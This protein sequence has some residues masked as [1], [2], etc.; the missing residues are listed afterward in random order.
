MAARRAQPRLRRKKTE[1]VS[2]YIDWLA[3]VRNAS[4]RC[5]V[6]VGHKRDA[7]VL[8]SLG[9]QHVYYVQE[10]YFHFLDGIAKLK[11]EC[12]LLFDA[13]HAGNVV[14]ERVKSDLQ[15]LGTTV[16]T[17]FRKLLFLS[18][19]KELGGLLSFIHKHVAV[20]ARVHAALPRR[21]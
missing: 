12:I 21:L 13:T 20:S 5:A 16:N 6:I 7:D 2:I 4:K 19:S 14:C 9:V 18:A 8:A 15:Q 11:R 3:H 1:S 10:P 17:R